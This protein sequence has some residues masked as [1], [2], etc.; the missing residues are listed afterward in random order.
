MHTKLMVMEA[1]LFQQEKSRKREEE[2]SQQNVSTPRQ[3]ERI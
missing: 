1:L 3:V 2:E